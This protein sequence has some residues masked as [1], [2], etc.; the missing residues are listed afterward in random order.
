VQQTPL[1]SAQ[2]PAIHANENKSLPSSSS[3]LPG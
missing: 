2:H 3:D 1:M